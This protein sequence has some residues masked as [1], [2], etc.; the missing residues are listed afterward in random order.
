MIVFGMCWVKY[1]IKTNDTCLFICF[2]AS[3]WLVTHSFQT[4]PF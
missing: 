4:A 2:Y 1:V 3:L